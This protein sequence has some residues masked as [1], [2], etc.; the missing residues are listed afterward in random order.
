MAEV[1]YRGTKVVGQPWTTPITQVRRRVD[2]V[3]GRHRCRA[4]R[5][6]RHV[7]LSEC[8]VVSGSRSSSATPA[9]F[10][11]PVPGHV[12]PGTR[13]GALVPGEEPDRGGSRVAEAGERRLETGGLLDGAT[14][15]PWFRAVARFRYGDDGVGKWN[16][17]LGDVTPR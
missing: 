5:R 3:R 15:I 13:D 6:W 14:V 17:D 2:A 12:K 9:R 7:I 16:L 1:R 8:F 11:D 4:G 10:T